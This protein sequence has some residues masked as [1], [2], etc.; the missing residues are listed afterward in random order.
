M[1]EHKSCKKRIRS[2]AK[3]R[4][5]NRYVK[6]TIAT[7]T[8]KVKNA[9]NKEEMEKLLPDAYSVLDKAVKSGVIHKNNAARRKARLAQFVNKT[10]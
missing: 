2:D 7:M 4:A 1:P 8:K 9:E 5:Q 10:K 3:K 6:R